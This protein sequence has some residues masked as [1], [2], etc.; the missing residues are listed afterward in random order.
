MRSVLS[1]DQQSR[2][3]GSDDIRESL[4]RM[5]KKVMQGLPLRSSNNPSNKL[6]LMTALSRLTSNSEPAMITPCLTVI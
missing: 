1:P 4:E 3:T 6:V 5:R 2:A